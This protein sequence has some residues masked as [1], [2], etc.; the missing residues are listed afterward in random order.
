MGLRQRVRERSVNDVLITVGL[1]A[2]ALAVH[3][4]LPRADSRHALAHKHLGENA[5]RIAGTGSP[6]YRAGNR[7]MLFFDTEGAQ[8]PIRGAIIID[9]E[10]VDKVLLLQSREGIDRTALN[11]QK[12]LDSFHGR[13]TQGTLVVDVVSGA[14]VSSRILITEVNRQLVR[15]RKLQVA[16]LAK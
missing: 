8:G 6:I 11:S 7:A 4:L 14:T 5:Q 10:S 13:S 1:L 3:V 12:L 9:N 2:I 15:W 16:G